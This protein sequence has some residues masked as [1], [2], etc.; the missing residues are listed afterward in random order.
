MAITNY[1]TLQAAI[2]S[3]FNRTDLPTTDLIQAAE[4]T[5]NKVI[6]S[7]YMIASSTVS[8]SALSDRGALPTDLIDVVYLRS[9]TAATEVLVKRSADWIAEQQRL[10]LSTP[11]TPLY[12][13]VLGTSLLVCPVPASAKTY[14]L[15]YYQEIPTLSNSNPTNWLLQHHPDLY[16]YTALMHASVNMVEDQRVDLFNKEIVQM[17]QGLLSTNQTTTLESAGYSGAAA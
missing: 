11:A 2:A 9:S 5:L 12:Y 1:S 7:R 3:W 13:N 10:R 4:A 15:S 14:T 8:V 17:V 6:R 16:L